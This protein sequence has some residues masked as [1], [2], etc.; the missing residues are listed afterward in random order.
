MKQQIRNHA[1]WAVKELE[2]S[3]SLEAI[4]VYRCDSIDKAR[5]GDFIIV[6][7]GSDSSIARKLFKD[8]ICKNS[9]CCGSTWFITSKIWG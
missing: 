4:N 2:K 7:A 5:E 8:V 1:Q 3:L 6:A 9:F